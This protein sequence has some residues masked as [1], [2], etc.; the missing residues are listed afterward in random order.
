M[1]RLLLALA[2][3]FSVAGNARADLQPL[4]PWWEVLQMRL[5]K[6]FQVVVSQP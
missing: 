5:E 6:P 1:P 2:G 3:V 4:L